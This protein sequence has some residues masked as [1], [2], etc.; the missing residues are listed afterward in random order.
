MPGP[1]ADGTQWLVF[2]RQQVPLAG[3]E[4]GWLWSAGM[5]AWVSLHGVAILSL[6]R[7]PHQ[8]GDCF[9]VFQLVETNRS[10]LLAS[11]TMSRPT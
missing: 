8:G 6:A 5:E 7:L 1:R 4:S 2:L 9:M 11:R 10:R 3:R